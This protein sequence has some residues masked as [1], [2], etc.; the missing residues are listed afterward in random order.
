MGKTPIEEA[1]FRNLIGLHEKYMNNLLSR[2]DEG[3]IPDLREYFRDTWTMGLFHDR[4][5]EF[6][7]VIRKQLLENGEVKE[8][9]A[10]IQESIESGHEVL[11][12][13]E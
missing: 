2:F 1:N 12:V 5:N 4:F 9:M 7:S 3:I 8:L 6:N 10:S 11:R 13:D